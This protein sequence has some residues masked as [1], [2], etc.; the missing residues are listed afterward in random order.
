MAV[1]NGADHNLAVIPIKSSAEAGA[2][3]T[4]AFARHPQRVQRCNDTR[5]HNCEQ[6]S[7]TIPRSTPSA[8]AVH[9]DRVCGHK[10]ASVG[11]N[12]Q[13]QFADLLR[14]AEAL[15]RHIVEELLDQLGRGLRR[16]LKRRFD[17]S[18][19]D[20][21]R[22]ASRI[23]EQRRVSSIPPRLWPP[24]NGSTSPGPHGGAPCSPC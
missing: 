8:A 20:R 21:Q 12:E 13:N 16:A 9:I 11:A 1:F 24:R 22:L 23:R 10:F 14:L 3:R 17:R 15:H 6:Q 4:A 5:N 2:E 19:R 7:D 18:G